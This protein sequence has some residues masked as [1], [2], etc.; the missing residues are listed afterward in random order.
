MTGTVTIFRDDGDQPLSQIVLGNGDRVQ[1]A[2]DGSGLIVTRL[3]PPGP[4]NEILF[5]APAELVASICAGLV[6][7]K[8]QS[9]ASP[10]RLLTA[11]VQPIGSA[12][13]VRAAFQEAVVS[14]S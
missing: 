10:L 5:R 2:L 12:A 13:E 7:P 1:L 11:I 3:G 9:Q 6:G 8:R 4:V 14:I